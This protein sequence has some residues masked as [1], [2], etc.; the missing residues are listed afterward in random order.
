MDNKSCRILLIEQKEIVE[1]HPA[2]H[3]FY[4]FQVSGA[5]YLFLTNL[6]RKGTPFSIIEMFEYYLNVYHIL[7]DKVYKSVI[8]TFNQFQNNY[9]HYL[10]R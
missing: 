9:S 5:V 10:L 8:S 6:D 2:T 3:L 1:R 4:I 7:Q